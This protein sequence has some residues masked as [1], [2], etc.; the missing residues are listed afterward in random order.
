MP[1]EEARKRLCVAVTTIA[2]GAGAVNAT[3]SVSY[4]PIDRSIPCP[5]LAMFAGQSENG[6]GLLANGHQSFAIGGTCDGAPDSA[7]EF[8][9]TGD[10]VISVYSELVA[11][12]S[13]IMIFYIAKGSGNKV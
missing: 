11:K 13:V 3:L 9:V 8:Q 10:R 5:I 6:G 4:P 2:A 12:A 7:G 1:N